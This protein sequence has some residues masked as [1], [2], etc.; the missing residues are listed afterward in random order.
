MTHFDVNSFLENGAFVRLPSGK[1]RLW[2]GPFKLTKNENYSANSIAYMDFFG[3]E[4]TSLDC[5]NSVLETD[6]A[7]LRKLFSEFS[8]NEPLEA[9]NFLPPSFDQFQVSF[10]EIM[11]RIHRGEI[12]KAVPIVF[13]ECPTFPTSGQIARILHNVLEAS[14][15]LYPFGIWQKGLGIIGATPEILFRT[16]NQNVSTMALAGTAPLAFIDQL[17]SDRKELMEHQIVVKD[18]QSRLSQMGWVRVEPTKAVKI[19]SLAH[20]KTLMD[21]QV[22]QIDITKLVKSL[23]PTAALGVYPRNYGLAWLQSLPY[24]NRRGVF[25]A[26]IIFP[27]SH[28]EALALVAIRCLQWSP[29]GS[30]IGTGCGLVK[31]SNRQKE[32]EELSLK[33][34]SVMKVLGLLS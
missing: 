25:G 6:T 32:W 26:P 2:Q 12:E 33:R 5:S 13:A 3:D 7:T 28:N 16:Q 1:L 34:S 10:Q 21:V 15:E 9:L 24:Q 29:E 18:I 14:E 22:S 4:L 20:L 19:G 30:K 11:G 31:D 27:L 17:K 23:H 8:G